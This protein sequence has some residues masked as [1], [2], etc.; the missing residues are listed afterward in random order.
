MGVVGVPER[1]TA[2]WCSLAGTFWR[3]AGAHGTLWAWTHLIF[4]R[5]IASIFQTITRVLR[6]ARDVQQCFLR[7]MTM[8]YRWQISPISS[9][10]GSHMGL[11][12]GEPWYAAA[13]NRE[14][15][16]FLRSLVRLRFRPR[17]HSQAL[18]LEP[19]LGIRAGNGGQRLLL[20]RRGA[21]D[22]ARLEIGAGTAMDIRRSAAA[23]LLRS[24]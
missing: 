23:T 8:N 9:T 1:E 11:A 19:G 24:L 15:A 18:Q 5:T 4:F 2:P 14:E 3:S 22:H 12:S 6:M 16:E 17:S 7:H 10:G 13:A 20:E 21:D